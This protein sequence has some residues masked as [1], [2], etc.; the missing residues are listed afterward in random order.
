M[1]IIVQVVD[2]IAA[3]SCPYIQV[4]QPVLNLIESTTWTTV[5]GEL[6]GGTPDDQK[7]IIWTSSDTSILEAYGQNGVGKV[8]AKASGICYLTVSHVKA[9]YEQK[10][11]CIC[12]KKDATEYSI[13]VDCQNIIS[14][15]PNAGDQQITASLINGS[16]AD[17]YNFNWSLDVFNIVSL[18]YSGN[19]AVIT[20]LQEGTCTLT[21]SHPKAAY[22]QKI[23][24]KVQSY[25]TFGFSA[26]NNTI[27]EGTTKFVNMEVPASSVKTHIVYTTNNEKICTISGTN[28]VAQIT[29]VG[30]GTC[31]VK[32]QLVATATNIVQAE[33]DML[34]YVS[35]ADTN[36]VYISGSP[37]VYTI[38]AGERRTLSALVVGD[39]ITTADYYNLKWKSE[40]PEICE[41]MGASTTGV[42]MGSQVYA[43]GKKAGETLITISH[44]KTN[45]ELVYYVIVPGTEASKLTLNKSY[46]SL[47]KSATATLKATITGGSTTDYNNIVW[48]ADK[49]EGQEICRVMGY[50]QEVTI[51][52][53]NAGTTD[54]VA[55][56][57]NGSQ[58]KCQVVVESTKGITFAMTTCKVQPGETKQIKY[59]V[60]P[61]NAGLTWVQ[62]DDKYYIYSDAGLSTSGT[63]EGFVE[64]TGVKE[65]N[66]SLK[67]ATSYGNTAT[68]Q[69]QCTWDYNFTVDRTSILGTP[70]DEIEINYS[71]TPA[72]SKI[73]FEEC[74]FA[75]LNQYQEPDGSGKLIVKPKKEGSGTINLNAVNVNISNTS[76]FKTIPIRLDF[77][78]K[79]D[80]LPVIVEKDGKFSSIDSEKNVLISD[81]ENVY[82][83]VDAIPEQREKADYIID[84]ITYVPF[85]DKKDEITAEEVSNTPSG[86][87]AASLLQLSGGEDIIDQEYKFSHTIESINGNQW[88]DIE[89]EGW[90]EYSPNY[91][92]YYQEYI[93]YT[94]R[95][96]S[97]NGG[98][99]GYLVDCYYFRSDGISTLLDYQ[100]QGYK[101]Y[102]SKAKFGIGVS[103][104]KQYYDRSFSVSYSFGGTSSNYS[105]GAKEYY[106]ISSAFASHGGSGPGYD[107][108]AGR[109]TYAV[110]G[111]VI[112]S[113]DFTI[114][115]FKAVKPL[116][117][118]DSDIV[119]LYGNSTRIED[120]SISIQPTYRVLTEPEYHSISETEA[121]AL[122]KMNPYKVFV[123]VLD[124]TAE[125]E[126]VGI[127]K[128][129]YYHL[130]KKEQPVQFVVYKEKRNCSKDQ[131]R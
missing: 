51:Y 72:N 75:V 17:K 95:H 98:G 15:K 118:G 13:S 64:I 35:P 66:S 6:V 112:G 43:V 92:E 65:G 47:E 38:E 107:F 7:N 23:V 105:P 97:S 58:A 110:W 61:A 102:R 2:P 117:N 81:G 109:G 39:G 8:R 22:D 28:S 18:T 26:A 16:M 48:T 103:E 90:E 99:E 59:T 46:I 34:V 108:T 124:D 50:G 1:Y 129:Q 121:N 29:G 67:V 89:A 4:T 20:P 36:A 122:L 3:A 127:I 131:T 71:V 24:I 79:L 57:P 45:T 78:Y 12:D 80:L 96:Y 115:Y 85:N 130:N 27:V 40:N 62:T 52:G 68:L 126:P 111:D 114:Y 32:A 76:I 104:R 91:F 73:D 123:N 86:Y 44:P 101:I 74:D 55:T 56:L 49:N 21:V 63:G 87:D 5:N 10:I 25:D 30:S 42:V 83:S 82:L 128:V 37:T 106:R 84:S 94:G 54:V 31:T 93:S 9:P 70:D 33:S 116:S 77:K 19:T 69:I 125:A 88:A 120:P 100:N 41:V 53:I 14:I 11:L 60:A 119:Y 113:Q